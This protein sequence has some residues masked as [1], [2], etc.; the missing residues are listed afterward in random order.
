MLLNS[1]LVSSYI[2]KSLYSSGWDKLDMNDYD[3]DYNLEEGLEP[4]Y[5]LISKDADDVRDNVIGGYLI[6]EAGKFSAKGF[7]IPL[8]IAE[9]RL[10]FEDYFRENPQATLKNEEPIWAMPIS[11]IEKKAPDLEQACINALKVARSL[12][13]EFPPDVRDP[14]VLKV[15]AKVLEENRSAEYT[16]NFQPGEL[17]LVGASKL[18]DY[19]IYDLM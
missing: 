17:A 18:S 12:A 4:N 6:V 5:S 19:R 8:A 3:S 15:R 9:K 10:P 11:A 1:P 13:R 7:Y 14:V 2:T 16:S